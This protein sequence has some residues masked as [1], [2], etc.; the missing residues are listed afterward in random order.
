MLIIILQ[1]LIRLVKVYSFDYNLNCVEDSYTSN[2]TYERRLIP[3]L[4]SVANGENNL[5]I[6][7]SVNNVSIRFTELCQKY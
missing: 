5:S 3:I 4:P 6:I 2:F 1:I 7:L